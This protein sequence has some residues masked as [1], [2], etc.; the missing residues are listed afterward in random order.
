MVDPLYSLAHTL[1]ANDFNISSP[2]LDTDLPIGDMVLVQLG[3]A[4][5]GK[6]A[7]EKVHWATGLRDVLKEL[8]EKNTKDPD[9]VAAAIADYRRAFLRDPSR[10][11]NI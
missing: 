10:V 11:L 5:P 6:T 7:E 9:V 3:T 8:R 4:N 1:F 2:S